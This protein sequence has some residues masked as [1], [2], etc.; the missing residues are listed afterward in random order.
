MR[1]CWAK[2]YSK[3]EGKLSREHLVSSGIFEQQNIFVQGFEWCKERE[4]KISVA[5]IT[6]KVLC[7]RH[8]NSLSDIDKV[9]IDAVRIIESTL[10]DGARSINTSATKKYI[11]GYNFERWLL[12]TAI[13]V[14][15]N[16]KNH[17]GVGMTDSEQGKPCSYLLAVVFGELNFSHKMGLYCLYPKNQFRFKAGSFH[18]FPIV[19]NKMIGAF[20][21][22][23]R[24][25]DFLLNLFP[26]HAP[27][28]LRQLGINE[29]T[30]DHDYILDAEPIYRSSSMAV[31][32]GNN[33][34][35]SIYFKW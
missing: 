28:P 19:K 10:P 2:T 27:P 11:D 8:N 31:T 12:K 26:D 4:K 22:H 21:F 23:V 30:G 32:N 16:G 15:F 6:S 33:D 14:S 1:N 17:I 3:C 29:A 5:S 18:M 7:E 34:P 24:G 25:I 35:Y 13:N 9:G 20:V